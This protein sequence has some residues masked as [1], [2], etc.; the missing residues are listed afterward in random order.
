MVET[1]KH[2][3]PKTQYR[4]TSK[5]TFI[6]GAFIIAISSTFLA[7]TI[8]RPNYPSTLTEF[9]TA[10][11]DSPSFSFTTLLA[12]LD[13]VIKMASAIPRQAPMVLPAV[14]KHTATV[15]FAH[16]LGDT[17]KGWSDAAGHWRSKPQLSGVKWILPTAPNIPISIVSSTPSQISDITVL[18][19]SRI[20]GCKCLAG[21]T[22]YISSLQLAIASKAYNSTNTCCIEIP[23]PRRQKPRIRRPQRRH[24]RHPPLPHLL[25]VPHRPRDQ[26]RHP[27]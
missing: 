13:K 17:A 24:S 21:L 11:H 7:F 1:S 27:F 20:M 4:S 15:I 19:G 3:S 8:F 6:L 16:G 22:L 12:D 14:S 25:S 9:K 23:R 10:I 5:T 26:R 18:T 2:Q